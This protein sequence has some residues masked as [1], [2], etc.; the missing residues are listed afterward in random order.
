VTLVTISLLAFLATYGLALIN[1]KKPF[2]HGRYMLATIFP[3]VT[4]VSDRI[5]GRHFP[6]LA[7]YAF[8]IEGRPILPSLGFFMADIIL[9]ICIIWD[10]RSH[11]TK[12]VFIT[13]LCINLAYQFCALNFH[14][15]GF[16]EAFCNAFAMWPLS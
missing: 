5:I 9:I 13:I 11:K 15:Y 16:W 3:M 4:P 12:Y 7:A 6:D 10:Y 1:S 14:K 8:T 2:I